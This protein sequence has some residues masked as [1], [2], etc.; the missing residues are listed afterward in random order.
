MISKS[1]LQ[2]H[3][4]PLI[5]LMFLSG[6]FSS[7]VLAGPMVEP[8][9]VP[10]Q[11]I[12]PRLIRD[13]SGRIHLVYFKKIPALEKSRKGDLYYRQWDPQRG[14]W[15]DS[16]KV[17]SQSYS[18]LGPVS[19]ASIAIDE[20]GR[21]HVVWFLPSLGAYRYSRSNI[22]RSRFEDERSPVIAHSDGLEAE[23]SI[24]IQGARITISWHA[25]D[26]SHEYKRAV[27]TLTSTDYGQT[28]GTVKLASDPALGACAC[29]SLAT[30]FDGKGHLQ[31]AYRSAIRDEGRHMQLLTMG[32]AGKDNS[33][34]TVGEWQL[35]SCPVSTNVLN[36]D[37][38]A[39][40]I[41]G[42]ILMMNVTDGNEATL[43]SASE[44]RQ[45][46]P[47]IAINDN[48]DR[49]LVWGEAAGY[50][51]GGS[52]QMKMYN[53]QSEVIETADHSSQNIPQFSI[54]AAVA[55]P[56]GSFL[57]LY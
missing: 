28:F 50:F 21:I 38:L 54:A 48:G 15:Q 37:W 43:V 22:G 55:R 16:I 46:H 12:Q 14:D 36:G 31:I 40:E 9:R 19:K 32:S 26:L 24:A 11:G 6:S 34:R 18:H 2:A 44:I 29:C 33:L 53:A 17:S 41:K 13:H 57:V 56:D 7:P 3:L 5:L 45:K 8:G 51:A 20:A 25:G 1:L 23:A 27:Y 4:L 10:D 42:Q 49:L 39:F 47:A 30:R 52:L 35:N